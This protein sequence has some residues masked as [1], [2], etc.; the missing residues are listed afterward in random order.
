ML[1]DKF[2]ERRSLKPFEKASW[3]HFILSSFELFGDSNINKYF[4]LYMN[5]V[6]NTTRQRNWFRD[7][8]PTH[9]F[10]FLG[11][12]KMVKFILSNGLHSFNTN[13]WTILHEAIEF[14]KA[15]AV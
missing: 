3:N 9:E 1:L 8:T 14:L 10:V 6:L 15:E 4:E 7:Y 11:N 2:S 12:I 5:H 13:G